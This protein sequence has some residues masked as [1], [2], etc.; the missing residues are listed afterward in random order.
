V[1]TGAALALPPLRRAALFANAG[2]WYDAVAAA[3]AAQNLDGHAALDALI[4]QVGLSDA[5][6]YAQDLSRR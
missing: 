5:A 3:A 1:D 4:H 6:G 2:L